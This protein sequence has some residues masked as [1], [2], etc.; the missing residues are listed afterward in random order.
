[1]HRSKVRFENNQSKFSNNRRYV[2]VYDLQE[3]DL[4]NRVRFEKT[5]VKYYYPSGGGAIGRNPTPA[6]RAT[7]GF[8]GRAPTPADHATSGPL[9]FRKLLAA[10][11]CHPGL[12]PPRHSRLPCCANP[13][14]WPP[15]HTR[16]PSLPCPSGL[17]G[18]PDTQGHPA[19]PPR[20]PWPAWRAR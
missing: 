15:R 9:H 20:P 6:A 8:I 14:L 5:S 1:M 11:P 3:S 12:R 10:L 13:A 7:S 16:R 17:P 19:V 4:N 18:P 2:Y